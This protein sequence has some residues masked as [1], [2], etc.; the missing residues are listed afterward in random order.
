MKSH[1]KIR[2][3]GAKY[4]AE[5]VKE[6]KNLSELHLNFKYYYII[7]HNNYIESKQKF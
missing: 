2:E 5:S 1:N 3:N 6:L 7:Y 4:I